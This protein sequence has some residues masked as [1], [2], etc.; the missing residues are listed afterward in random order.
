MPFPAFV[1]LVALLGADTPAANPKLALLPFKVVRMPADLGPALD[2]H[3]AGVV[4]ARNKYQ[5][6]T[7]QDIN[8][9]LGLERMKDATNCTDTTCAADIGGALGVDLMLSP[10]A[11]A[12]GDMVEITIT[13]IDVRHAQVLGRKQGRVPRDEKFLAKGID[14]AVDQLLGPDSH[15]HVSPDTMPVLI[16]TPDARG[17]RVEAEVNDAKS[18]CERAVT[19]GHAC[20]LNEPRGDVQITAKAVGESFRLPLRVRL[21][22]AEEG[23]TVDLRG[24]GNLALVVVGGLGIGLGVVAMSCSALGFALDGPEAGFAILGGG[25]AITGLGAWGVAVGVPKDH[26]TVTPGIAKPALSVSSRW[27]F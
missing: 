10:Q 20:D 16:T 24:S 19:P 15:T 7:T 17:Y 27:T 23:Y 22:Y 5:L 25:V 2:S 11:T 13:L 14:E 26:S 6:V 9:M 8:A 12:L 1:C 21:N 4:D 3:L 18:V